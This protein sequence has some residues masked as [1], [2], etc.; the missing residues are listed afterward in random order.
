MK[1]TR[2]SN[3]APKADKPKLGISRRQFMKNAGITAG[4]IAAAS[5]LGAGMMRRAEA[6]DVPHDAPI[7][8][9]RTICSACA[10]GCGLYAEVQNGVW[11]GQEP[12]FDHPFNAGGHCAKGAALREHGHGEKRLKYPMKLEGG[13][14]KRIS[15]DQAINEVG[16]KMLKIR[17]ESGPDS[18][19][20]MGSA[21]FSNEGCYMYRKLAAMWGT[22]NVDHSA[23]ICHSTTVA[24]VAN[25]WGYGA[26]T[27]SFND[28][29]NAR[30]IFFIGA[31]PAEAHPVSM[32]HILIA[33][34]KNNA[35]LI[36]VDPRFSRTA[37][38]ADLHCS[39][40]PGTDIPF[41]YGMLWHIF[42]NGWEDKTF[43][44]ERVFEME[45]I[46]AEAKKFPPKEVA[47][48][49]GCSEEYLYQA[50]KMMADNRPG[51]V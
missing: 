1:L 31:N 26:Q 47:N 24:G 18:V 8:V 5:M 46:R 4:G 36:V 15:W 41:I 37:A 38:H 17:Q 51:T 50:A 29:Q 45:T 43:I 12:A 16:D 27:N 23:R 35:K 11:T 40:R 20:F 10:V 6:K 33:K 42:E 30:A 39:I 21:K 34:E 2:T 28:I 22:N 7:E 9:K 14:W 32:Q 13:K 19:Y 49:T 48:I 3:V 44:K 25:T